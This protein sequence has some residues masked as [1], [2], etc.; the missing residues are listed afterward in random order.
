[1]A[2]KYD[3]LSDEW[4]VAA[5]KIRDELP[6]PSSPPAHQVKMNLIITEAPFNDAAEIKV[7]VD[8]SGGEMKIDTGHIDVPDLTVTVDYET[9]KAIFIDQNPAAGMQAFMAGKV[10][11]Q[12]DMTK[13]MAMQQVTPDP[14]AAEVASRIKEITV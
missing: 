12:G 6:A 13:L 5:R 7:H 8:T 3:F 1:V 9:A 4:F 2:D 11:V 10:K 14:Q